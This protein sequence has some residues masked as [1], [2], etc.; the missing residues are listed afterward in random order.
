MRS[1]N[2]AQAIETMINTDMELIVS[3]LNIMTVND[4]ASILNNLSAE[5]VAAISRQMQP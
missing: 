1:A 2:I 5:T 4:R 3:V